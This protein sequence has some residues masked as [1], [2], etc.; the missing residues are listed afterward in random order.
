MTLEAERIAIETYFTA[1]WAD[2]LPWGRDGQSFKPDI[3]TARLTIQTGQ[4]FQG[5][6]GRTLNRIDNIGIVIVTI[7]TDAQEGSSEWRPYAQAALD[8][9]HGK[10]IGQDGTIITAT[11]DAFI[12]FSPVNPNGREEQHPYI[13]GSNKQAPF[14]ITNITAP[15]ARYEF[16]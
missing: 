3:N 16:K 1:A 13:S 14:W 4:R 10:T 7:Y 12:R 11:A 5:S 6:I 9:F 8:I 15:F 2:R